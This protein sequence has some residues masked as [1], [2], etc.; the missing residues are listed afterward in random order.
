MIK[1]RKSRQCAKYLS[2]KNTSSY[3]DRNG[4]VNLMDQGWSSKGGSGG[5]GPS[6]GGCLPN[7]FS[8]APF[9][10]S[11]TNHTTYICSPLPTFPSSISIPRFRVD[12]LAWC[13]CWCIRRISACHMLVKSTKFRRL[14]WH[15]PWQQAR[16]AATTLR[17]AVSKM[18]N[19]WQRDGHTLAE[20]YYNIFN[21]RKMY[22]EIW[23]NYQRTKIYV[24]LIVLS[25]Y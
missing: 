22:F 24:Y 5:R 2:S 21:V 1:C 6:A 9:A 3:V 18:C 7:R 23:Q 25:S 8:A 13:W 11:V 19:E 20:I 17:V 4:L 10:E 14:L 15:L 16:T 12:A